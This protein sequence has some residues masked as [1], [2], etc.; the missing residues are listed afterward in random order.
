MR[1]FLLAFVLLFA[2]TSQ[3]DQL[4]Y[5]SKE[6]A[7]KAV[8]KIKKMKS[9]YLFCGCCSIVEPKKAKILEVSYAHTGYED[10][11]EVSITYQKEDGTEETSPV[12]LAYIW[13]K[14]LFGYKTVGQILGLDHD[15]CV[16]LKSWNDPE[17]I[18][19][20]I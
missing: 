9:I 3:A 18:E 11:Y 15:P 13:K 6:D 17:N 14:G 1:S 8:S 7:I 19:K 20:D 12:D 5:I 2:F 10:Y 4:A 16:N